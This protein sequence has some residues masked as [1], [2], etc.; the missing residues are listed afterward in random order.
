LSLFL[1][2]SLSFIF[3]VSVK[4]AKGPQ[5]RE[6]KKRG[7]RVEGATQI[8]I[9]RK[10]PSSHNNKQKKKHPKHNT[11][12]DKNNDTY[13]KQNKMGEGALSQAFKDKMIPWSDIDLG[14][15]IGQG[16]FG[17]VHKG[18][19]KGRDVAVKIP[20]PDPPVPRTAADFFHEAHIQMALPPNPNLPHVVGLC[21][22]EDHP[23]IVFDF[24]DG[25]GLGE[26]LCGI[27]AMLPYAHFVL[28]CAVQV[29]SALCVLHENGV[30][31]RDVAL[32]NIM[33]TRQLVVKLLDFGLAQ[34]GDE[35]LRLSTKPNECVPLRWAPPETFN[36][37]TGGESESSP[38]A[39]AGVPFSTKTDCWAVGVLLWE[40]F[41]LSMPYGIFAGP[42]EL[43][44]GICVAGRRLERPPQCPRLLYERVMLPLFVADPNG[45]PTMA[46]VKEELCAL[47]IELENGGD[48]GGYGPHANRVL[49]TESLEKIYLEM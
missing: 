28:K 27:G 37:P 38:I 45:R 14:E 47:L 30:V 2:S 48:L 42:E 33:V 3:C 25:W 12:N 19:Y 1:F 36:V 16:N 13:D 41:T 32:R 15:A 21:I 29:V 10:K 4:I 17:V 6:R 8:G 43:R 22:D 35:T 40:M 24:I 7:G 23:A 39:N 46:E 20:R 44:H 9:N 18:R 11:D 34:Y 26:M 31:H 5:K 49:N